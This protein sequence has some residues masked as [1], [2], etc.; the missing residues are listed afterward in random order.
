MK[1]YNEKEQSWRKLKQDHP[2]VANAIEQSD[3]REYLGHGRW[4]IDLQTTPCD[5]LVY[6]APIQNEAE[7]FL[8]KWGGK[9]IW[10]EGMWRHSYHL[11]TGVMDHNRVY[12]KDQEGRCGHVVLRSSDNWQLWEPPIKLDTRRV[13]GWWMRGSDY[14][15]A[16]MVISI[17]TS[18]KSL[19]RYDEQIFNIKDLEGENYT[20]SR[21]PS[22]PLDQWQ[23]LSEICGGE[24]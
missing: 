12:I 5:D 7:K 4:R 3:D 15:T 9:K 22:A 17:G 10:Q 24:S 6:R 14:T 16:H 11:V 20:F 23:T 2:D 19:S 21:D 13:A 18:G 8:E 1:Y